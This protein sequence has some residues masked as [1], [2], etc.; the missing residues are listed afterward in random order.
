MHGTRKA[1]RCELLAASEELWLAKPMR[2]ILW[3]NLGPDESTNYVFSMGRLPPKATLLHQPIA[4]N[5]LF[6]PR[7]PTRRFQS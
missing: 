7:I 4:T 2:Q 3:P 6:E 5:L 1:V